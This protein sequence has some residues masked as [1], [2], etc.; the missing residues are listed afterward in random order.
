MTRALL[1]ILRRV[2]LIAI[3]GRCCGRL[4][5]SKNTDL[6]MIRHDDRCNSRRSRRCSSRSYADGELQRL[7]YRYRKVLTSWPRS[8]C[9]SSQLVLRSASAHQSSFYSARWLMSTIV[10][11]WTESA[12]G[13]PC[14]Y[15]PFSKS[16]RA[17]LR[18]MQS[19]LSKY[20]VVGRLILYI[21]E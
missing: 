6:V 1:T 3:P 12:V 19:F 16:R 15:W 21:H 18:H 11:G 8:S 9:S 13:H 20:E 17:S 7:P 2:G 10:S 5:T 14:R 4:F